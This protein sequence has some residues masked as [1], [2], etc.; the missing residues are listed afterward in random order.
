MDGF[1]ISQTISN[2]MDQYWALIVPGTVLLVLK[3]Y[4][5]NL[6]TYLKVRFSDLPCYSVGA[7]LYL[8]GQ[9]WKVEKIKM[10][11]VVLCQ[12]TDLGVIRM[13]KPIR[14]Y[15]G[16]AISYVMEA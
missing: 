1:S 8:G 11:H 10:S 5:A 6:T 2:L 9:V 14:E 12:K 7:K 3:G 15:Y 13:L 16:R 4:V